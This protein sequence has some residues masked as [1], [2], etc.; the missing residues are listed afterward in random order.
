[1]DNLEL[2]QKTALF[3]GSSREEIDLAAG[4]FQERTMKAN[5]TIFTE[6]MPAA[7]LYIV[8][9]GN[10]R[11]TMM[12]GEGEEKT[13]LLLGPG[14]FFGELALIQDDK[15]MV[16]ARAETSVDLLVLTR[17][18]FQGLANLAPQM[19]ARITAAIAKLLAIRVK[20]YSALLRDLLLG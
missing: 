3:R 18:D 13:L 4:Q 15:R 19:A 11:I 9:S 8:K 5:A 17:E 7:S 1:M 12:A 2:L 16:S 6:M 14:E 20:A 10:V